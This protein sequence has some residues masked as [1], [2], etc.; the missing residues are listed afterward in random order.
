MSPVDYGWLYKFWNPQTQQM[1]MIKFLAIFSLCGI[2]LPL[3]L[4]IIL[5][6]LRICQPSGKRVKLGRPMAYY[7]LKYAD[8]MEKHQMSPVEAAPLS[9][10]YKRMSVAEFQMRSID[11]ELFNRVK[12][13]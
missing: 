4:Y 11:V 7:K 12:H 9:D 6:I 5:R 1:K 2:M 3:L 13:G 8:L 10:R